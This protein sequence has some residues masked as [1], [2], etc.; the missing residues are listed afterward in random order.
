MKHTA[1]LIL[2]LL[3]SAGIGAA[4]V[5]QSSG[6][7]PAAL[8]PAA[9]STPGA[10]GTFFRSDITVVNLA[11][12]PQAVKIDWLAEGQ[13]LRASKT[14]TIP[15]GIAIRSEDFVREYL[16]LS[17]LGALVITAVSVDGTSDSS[18]SLWIN[19]R[20]WTPMP[21]S[22]GGTSSQSLPAIPLVSVRTTAARFV[23]VGGP[24]QSGG[25]RVNVGI[26]NLDPLLPQTF[27]ILVQSIGPQ[28]E[29][30]IATVPPMSMRQVPIG[31]GGSNMGPTDVSV[32]NVTDTGRIS[33]SWMAYASTID[34]VTG[35][36]WTELPIPLR[37]P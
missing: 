37:A 5:L 31:N 13:G 8:I 29:P 16:G 12:S 15:A 20:I 10:N 28:P 23:G 7:V 34:N 33:S 26:V 6:P 4:A 17:G 36:A 1:S 30:I 21:G 2:V 35:D 22:N 9:G 27:S 32:L 25:F 11:S 14:I 19:S 18:G 24:D 3:L